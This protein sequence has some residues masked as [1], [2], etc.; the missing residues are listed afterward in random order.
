MDDPAAEWMGLGASF[1]LQQD[2]ATSHT[3][4]PLFAG[5]QSGAYLSGATEILRLTL[6]E[7]GSQLHISGASFDLSSQKSRE[8]FSVDSPGASGF[9]AALE[10]IARKFDSE[11]SQRFSTA[12][13]KAL[14]P[15]TE[16][17]VAQ[18]PQ[19]RAELLQIALTADPSFGLAHI[20]LAETIGEPAL[21]N[22]DLNMFTP[23]DRARWV[24]FAARI[25]NAPVPEQMK[26]QEATLKLAPNNVE[27]LAS[28]GTLRYL[29]GTH[30]A[31]LQ[32][33][34]QAINLSPVNLAL[35]L[36]L[37]R[38]QGEDGEGGEGKDTAGKKRVGKKE[39]RVP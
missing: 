39:D 30:N 26:A 15:F 35:R 1:V 28:L 7:R 33:L 25:R 9:I 29:A 3:V 17:A 8:V 20:A 18:T 34:R 12:N 38:L 2:L 5:D 23:Y 16:A 31:G 19:A 14:K 22:V 32:L 36:Q 6:T 4:L 10:V 24:A 11:T 27:A 37:R 13:V 21:G